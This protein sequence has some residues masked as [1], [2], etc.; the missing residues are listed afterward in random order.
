M[1]R[2]RG[3]KTEKTT[4]L[5]GKFLQFDNVHVPTLRRRSH[6]DGE[7]KWLLQKQ[8]RKGK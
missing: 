7:N 4:G 6:G 2:R 8:A 5:Q 1:K 3:K